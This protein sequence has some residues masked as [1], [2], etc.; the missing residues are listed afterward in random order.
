MSLSLSSPDFS[1]HE[2]IPSLYTCDG[3]GISPALIWHAPPP[4]TQSLALIVDD[5]DAPRGVWS[6]WVLFNIPSNM[7]QLPEKT[8]IPTGATC[9]R[10]S[11]G[12]NEY[13]GPCPP[14]GTHRYFFTLYALDTVLHLNEKAAEQDVLTAMKGHILEQSVLIGLYSRS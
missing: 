12:K 4:H 9:G 13:G 2:F 11:W 14:H 6:H 5:P 8:M 3:K 1:N 10:N 7:R